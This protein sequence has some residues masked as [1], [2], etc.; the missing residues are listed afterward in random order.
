MAQGASRGRASGL[1]LG[2]LWTATSSSP[3]LEYSCA[4]RSS[5]AQVA[6]QALIRGARQAIASCSLPEALPDMD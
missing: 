2:R 3:R 4:R 1:D 6:P 5:L